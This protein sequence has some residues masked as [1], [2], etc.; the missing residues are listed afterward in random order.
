MGLCKLELHWL[1]CVNLQLNVH[2]SG[3]CS[4]FYMRGPLIS[5]PFSLPVIRYRY[6]YLHLVYTL[7]CWQLCTG[8][9]S[10]P[11]PHTLGAAQCRHNVVVGGVPSE[12]LR[13]SDSSHS[14]L[15]GGGVPIDQVGVGWV[16]TILNGTGVP[17]LKCALHK[18]IVW[19]SRLNMNP[20]NTCT[21]CEV[22]ANKPVFVCMV[23]W[24]I[25]T[26]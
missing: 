14:T 9:E 18:H 26:D 8:L 7:S 25:T 24:I 15:G 21:T 19:I 11:F 6:K 2:T 5:Q 17:W 12:P 22:K 4:S 1:K 20:K 23:Y 10:P 16:C 13:E 3:C